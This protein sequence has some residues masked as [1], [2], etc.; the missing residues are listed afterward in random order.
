VKLVPDLKGTRVRPSLKYIEQYA[1]SRAH[2]KVKK[3]RIASK[4]GTIV[5]ISR[6]GKC[7]RVRFDGYMDVHVLHP[8][9]VELVDQI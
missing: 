4:E 9:F 3:E 2:D 1:S 6:D 7:V 5:G 8:S